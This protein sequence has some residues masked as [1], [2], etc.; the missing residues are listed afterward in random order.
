MN[1]II[2]KRFFTHEPTISDNLLL[3]ALGER[4]PGKFEQQSL[5]RIDWI[6]PAT[7]SMEANNQYE[8]LIRGFI[9]GWIQR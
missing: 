3:R 1:P 2:S 9:D 7:Q 6:C 4:F 8:L 5:S